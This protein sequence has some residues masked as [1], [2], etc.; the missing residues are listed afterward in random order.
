MSCRLLGTAPIPRQLQSMEAGF[1]E[2]HFSKL[3]GCLLPSLKL[4]NRR[5]KGELLLKPPDKRD[6]NKGIRRVF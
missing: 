4:E 1:R 6:G 2:L 5:I 3:L